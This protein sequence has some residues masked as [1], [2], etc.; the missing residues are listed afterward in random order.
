MKIAELEGFNRNLANFR[1]FKQ[2]YRLYL[3]AN[4]ESYPGNEEKIMFVLSY[5][6]EGSV[7]L[8]AGSYINKAVALKNWG[9]WDEFTIQLEHNFT[10]RNEVR[11]AMERLDSQ[12]QG[13]E[14]ASVYFLRIE[15][16]AAAAGI[17]LLEDPHSI[18]RCE[19][20]L[21]KDLVDRIYSGGLIPNTYAGYRNHA[22]ALDNI[23]RSRA[24]W[25]EN[26]QG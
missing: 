20:G 25:K 18:L 1:R 23:A 3:C 21:N 10:D 26:H 11:Q 17:N 19:R 4:K 2:Q 12:K 6:K 13:R 14:G 22:I 16:H 15:Q 9:D 24:S 8:W 5:M 7:E